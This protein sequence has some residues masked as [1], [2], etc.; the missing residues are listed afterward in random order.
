MVV[1]LQSPVGDGEVILTIIF[2][3][4]NIWLLAGIVGGISALA[5]MEDTDMAEQRRDIRRFEEARRCFAC[6][7]LEGVLWSATLCLTMMLFADAAN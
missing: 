1:S 7:H 4:G 2:V 6:V 5:S 3:I